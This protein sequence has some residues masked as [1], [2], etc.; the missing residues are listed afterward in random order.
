MDEKYISWGFNKSKNLKKEDLGTGAGRILKVNGT[1]I[2]GAVT[3]HPNV[4]DNRRGK[5]KL[6]LITL[7]Q[8]K[9]RLQYRKF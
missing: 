4:K 3:S 9:I 2:N 8:P 6:D 7:H 1:H 5:V